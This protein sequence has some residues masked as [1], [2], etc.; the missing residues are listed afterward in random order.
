MTALVLRGVLTMLV[1][2]VSV[3]SPLTSA[4]AA[5]ADS[6]DSMSAITPIDPMGSPVAPAAYPLDEPLTVTIPRHDGDA[7]AGDMLGVTTVM[8]A[9]GLGL[10]TMI[11]NIYTEISKAVVPAALLGG[12]I[13][14]I[15]YVLS[16]YFAVI[17]KPSN[18]I[19][20]ILL[21]MMIFGALP[22]LIS[23]A[24]TLTSAGTP[25]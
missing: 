14:A 1:A 16:G 18:G 10:D 6:H 15:M 9:T 2:F 17:P 7:L 25:P 12:A 20:Q 13:W 11:E 5:H 4:F 3:F 21:A 24:Q 8:T 23:W 22:T 19:G